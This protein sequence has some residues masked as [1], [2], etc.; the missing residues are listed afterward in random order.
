MDCTTRALPRPDQPRL[1]EGC[2]DNNVRDDPPEFRLGPGQR[3][4]WWEE[5]NS[6]E[7]KKVA[8]V[9]TQS[10]PSAEGCIARRTAN[11]SGSGARRQTQKLEEEVADDDEL[12]DELD[13]DDLSLSP[14][15]EIAPSPWD[16]P[17]PPA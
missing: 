17:P 5:H 7:T 6:D 2:P 11:P 14:P 12:D 13:E 9:T 4:G 1:E 10:R 8:M 3:Y 16:T 15:P